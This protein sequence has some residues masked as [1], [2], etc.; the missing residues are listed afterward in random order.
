MFKTKGFLHILWGCI[1]IDPNVSARSYY[2]LGGWNDQYCNTMPYPI[3][4]NLMRNCIDFIE[5]YTMLQTQARNTDDRPNRI[6][7]D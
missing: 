7:V 5:E 4:R 2:T 6:T 1:F 3:F